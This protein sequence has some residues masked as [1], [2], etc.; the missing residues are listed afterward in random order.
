MYINV[1]ANE[2]RVTYIQQGAPIIASKETLRIHRQKTGLRFNLLNENH[3]TPVS[4]KN[5]A[6]SSILNTPDID[7]SFDGSS[8]TKITTRNILQFNVYIEAS[9]SYAV[10]FSTQQQN[11]DSAYKFMKG[12][13]GQ[14]TRQLIKR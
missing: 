14:I 3:L 1:H 10:Y 7:Q 6:V 2:S 13:A 5:K 4:N 9:D 8:E 11:I 12:L